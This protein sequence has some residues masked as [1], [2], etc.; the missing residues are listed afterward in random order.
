MGKDNKKVTNTTS[1]TTK[2]ALDSTETTEYFVIDFEITYRTP[3]VKDNLVDTFICLL[4]KI[5]IA[6]RKA[7]GFIW[8]DIMIG[9]LFFNS[10]IHYDLKK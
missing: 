3:N 9:W 6:I 4:P 8:I 2:P 10:R 7:D 1:T 5:D